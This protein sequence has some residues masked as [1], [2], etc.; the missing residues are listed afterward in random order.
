MTEHLGHG[1]NRSPDERDAANV[2][3][4]SRSKT[5]LTHATGQAVVRDERGRFLAR[6]DRADRERRRTLDHDGQ[7]HHSS[8]ADQAHDA[9]VAVH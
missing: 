8:E 1:K 5:V 4:G 9:R 6:A 3:N 7:E 2:R